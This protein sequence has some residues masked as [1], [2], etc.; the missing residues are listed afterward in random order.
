MEWKSSR[1]MRVRILGVLIGCIFLAGNLLS[2][3]QPI[4]GAEKPDTYISHN[5]E[6]EAYSVSIE[7]GSLIVNAVPPGYRDKSI[8]VDLFKMTKPKP[9][10]GTSSNYWD[11]YGTGALNASFPH[12]VP[13]PKED[14]L[15]LVQ[16]SIKTDSSC[17]S[18]GC[19]FTVQNG[20]ASFEKSLVYG[21][22]QKVYNSRSKSNTGL[23]YYLQP[24]TIEE[25][26]VP[27]IRAV[28]ETIVNKNDPDLVK[29]R[30]VHDWVAENIWYDYDYYEGSKAVFTQPVEVLK[31][32]RTICQGYADLTA[33]LL[34]SL[35]IP[36][37]LVIGDVIYASPADTNPETW[38]DKKNLKGHAWNEAYADGRWIIMD[39]TWDSHNAYKNGEYSEK[40]PPGSYY[41]DPTLEEFSINHKIEP[42]D[43][44]GCVD[45]EF[46]NQVSISNTSLTLKKGKTKQLTVKNDGTFKYINLKDAKITFSSSNPKVASV[47]KKGKVKAKKAGRAVI[48]TKVTLEGIT[49]KFKTRVSVK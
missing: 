3:A 20:A 41:F 48:T 15:Y 31:Y 32:K 10:N 11:N 22:N 26:D 43:F 36:T 18:W 38:D 25:S 29:I 9:E 8:A 19:R 33:E 45:A 30:K 14:G 2:A 17:E 39:T 13:L 12:T 28:A 35:G 40:R 49:L 6:E 34:R 47:S 27:Y 24:I 7:G 46:T 5:Q 44:L 42:D 21:H 37:I 23:G 4:Y 1:K 16:I